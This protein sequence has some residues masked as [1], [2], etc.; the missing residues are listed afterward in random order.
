MNFDHPYLTEQIIAYIGNKRKLLPLIFK[1]IEN[2]K[3]DLSENLRFFDVFAG[4]G[5]VSRFAKYL[6]FEVFSN[7]WESYSFILNQGFLR[8]NEADIENEFGSKKAFIEIIEKINNLSAPAE[9]AQY[10]AKYYSPKEFETEKVNGKIERLFYTREN[11]LII[12]KIRNYIERNPDNLSEKARNLLIALLIYESA[13]HTNTSGVFKAFHKEFGGHGKDAMKRITTPI[14][15]H[16]PVL[17]DS[18]K[19]MHI[20]Q[21]DSNELVKKLKGLDIAYLDPPYNQHQ[22]GSNYHMLNTVAKW[23]KIPAPLELNDKGELKEKAAIRHDWVNT[24]SNYCYKENAVESFK[25]LIMNIDSKFI[26]ISYSTDGIIPFEKMI[27]ICVNRGKLSL[28]TNEY[29]TYRGGKQSNKRQNSNIEFILCIDTAK[30][31]D[32]ESLEEINFL[33]KRKKALLLFKQKFSFDKLKKNF[34]LKD[35]SITAE[36]KTTGHKLIIRT[37]DYLFAEI[38]AEFYDLNSC[39]IEELYDDLAT[40]V[41]ETK[42]EEIKE[43]I[44]RLDWQDS[45][46]KRLIKL[47]PGLINKLANNKNKNSYYYWIEKIRN[48][49][50][51]NKDLYSLIADKIIRIENLAKIRITK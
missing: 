10:I 35:N 27:E 9:E 45:D 29:T 17:F 33:L 22:Y 37:K 8:F 30:K 1:A 32:Q 13:T 42:E 15:L 16:Y 20:F 24:R 50:N 21:E 44:I 25:E 31:S 51:S 41:C 11:G 38:P 23:D 43:V 19:A 49:N 18:D 34:F 6:G 26:L 40:C 12:D 39:E 48:L 4:S 2:T 47:L 5:V 3:L 46:K 7:D 14:A 36:L 28:V